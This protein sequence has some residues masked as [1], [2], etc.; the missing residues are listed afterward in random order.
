MLCLAAALAGGSAL[1]QQPTPAPA[2][3]A[4]V[5]NGIIVGY[6][7]DSTVTR[8]LAEANIQIVTKADVTH[9]RSF[10]VLSDSS[11]FFR[12]TDVPPG[13]YLLTFFHPRLDEL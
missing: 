8:P 5:P 3:P 11:G 10:S 4:P 1:A 13:E 12:V 2:A 9:G 6:I 7:F